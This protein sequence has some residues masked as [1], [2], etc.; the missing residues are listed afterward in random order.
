MPEPM[1]ERAAA[2]AAARA[3]RD[4]ALAAAST[5]H[6]QTIA[7][8]HDAY[9]AECRR[10]HDEYGLAIVEIE[11]DHPGE[12]D[13][14]AGVERYCVV[15]GRPVARE[16]DRCRDHGAAPTMCH[17]AVRPAQCTHPH[18]SPNHPEPTCSECGRLIPQETTDANS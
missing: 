18:R 9:T 14:P 12:P 4:T 15:S 7:A 2:L 3:M 8:A 5:R 16:G 10:A 17:T 1:T 13:L 11:I 6:T